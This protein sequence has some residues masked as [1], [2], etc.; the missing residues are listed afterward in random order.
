MTKKQS[1]L[2]WT[3]ALLC[4]SGCLFQPVAELYQLPRQ[5]LDNEQL[6]AEISKIWSAHDQQNPGVEYAN[7]V[8]GDNTATV[9]LHALGGRTVDTA[10]TFFRVPSAENPLKIYFFVLNDEGDY[11]PI[12]MVEGEGTNILSI[13]YANLNGI[14]RDEILVNWQSNQLAV[15]SLDYM[16]KSEF[17]T[18]LEDI[19]PATQMLS[20]THAGYSLCDLDRDG[21]I[22]L[23]ALRLDNA[24][25]NS[26]IELYQWKETALMSH[27]IAPLSAGITSI[28]QVVS[29]YVVGGAPALYV[30]GNLVDD[31][32]VTDIVLLDDDRLTNITLDF[33]LG[34]SAQTVRDHRDIGATDINNDSILE[35]PS[36]IPL[37]DATETGL[38]D[39]WLTNWSQY[40]ADGD[41]IHVYTTY[42]NVADGWYLIIP[43]HWIDKITISRD[44]T[45]SGQRTVVFS[46]WNV[47]GGPSTPFLAIYKLTGQNRFVRASLNN[48]FQLGGDST[49]IYATTFFEE[50]WD[51]GVDEGD[52]INNFKQIITSWN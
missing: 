2:I 23:T 27:S 42:H 22:D 30:S 3:V 24:G 13:E 12:A 18:S 45:I 34:V 20:T 39:F 37:P 11:V 15:Y 7:I 21:V 25:S 33:T 6:T 4:L 17:T 19:E 35:I 43:E 28:N 32:R 14:G 36:L 40:D 29:S 48:R 46:L 16:E 31:T 10:V 26:Y 52:L 9:Q 5:S 51:C 38:G 41:Q 1:L 47:A 8:S 50:G 44:D 49:T